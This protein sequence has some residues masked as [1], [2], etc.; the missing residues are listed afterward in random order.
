[1]VR[2]SLPTLLMLAAMSAAAHALP[3]GAQGLPTAAEVAVQQRQQATMPLPDGDAVGAAA[4][5]ATRVLASPE[6]Q[7]ARVGGNARI[8]KDVP[9]TKPPAGVLDALFAQAGQPLFPALGQ[10]GELMVLV[11]FSMPAETLKNLARQADQAGAVLVL[12][13]LVD[14]SL[15]K[16]AKAIQSVLGDEAGDSTFQVNPNVFRA[17]HVQDVPTFVL[18]RKPLGGESSCQMGTDYVSVRGD[19]TLAY[20]LRKL[21]GNAGWETLASQH[22]QVLGDGHE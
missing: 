4:A 21:G 18:A 14:G 16:T 9:V 8:L 11:S 15:D 7:P 10:E 5:K 22:L 1:M 3:V 19:V 17:Y 6:L 20:A 12:R 13:G 2:P